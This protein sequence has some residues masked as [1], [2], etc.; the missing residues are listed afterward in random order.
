MPNTQVVADRFHVMTQIN[1][2]IDAQRKKGRRSIEELIKKSKLA[3]EKAE[4]EIILSGN[5]WY[6]NSIPKV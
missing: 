1:K 2:E 4:Y 6:S 5:K 3:S